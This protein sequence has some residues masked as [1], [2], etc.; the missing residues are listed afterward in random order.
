MVE[1]P[2]VVELNDVAA[3]RK[4]STRAVLCFEAANMRVSP[5]P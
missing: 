4:S 5:A 1:L 3:T 2:D